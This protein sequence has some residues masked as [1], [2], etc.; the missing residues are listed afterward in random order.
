MRRN[1][2]TNILVILITLNCLAIAKSSATAA[3]D[4]PPVKLYDAD[5]LKIRSLF[6]TGKYHKLNA[7]FEEYQKACEKDIQWEV[8]LQTGFNFFSV[9]NVT[10][11]KRIEEWINRTPNSWVPILARAAHYSALAQ[12][13][14]GGA[15]AKDTSEQQFQD[16]RANL[17]V[18]VRDVDILLARNPKLFYAYDLRIRSSRMSSEFNV[19]N[20][21]IHKALRVFPG[22]Y[23]LRFR[24]M[25][26][27]RPRWGG[28]YEEMAQF[29]LES[30]PFVKKNP[31]INTLQGFVYDDLADLAH[32][33]GNL[34]LAETLYEKALSYGDN[35]TFLTGISNV[36]IAEGKYDKALS[37]IERAINLRPYAADSR[38]QRSR[39]FL[40]M[41]RYREAFDELEIVEI[42][43]GAG[44]D[45][46]PQLKRQIETRLKAIKK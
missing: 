12:S 4:I 37:V 23:L 25:R 13:A 42:L 19:D 1:K 26:S 3:P 33:R 32:N 39:V 2:T 29:A 16:M 22:S 24:H 7:L 5:I 38:I 31:M 11:T 46:A 8:S 34:Q 35:F 10:F 6:E 28:S 27:I 45:G 17:A 30:L 40:A 14:R 18:V 44:S 43:G 20:F 36:Y 21:F 15:W 9:P 41:N